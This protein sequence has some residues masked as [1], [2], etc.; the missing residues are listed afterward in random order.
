MLW[1]KI[2]ILKHQYQKNIL[3]TQI[4]SH[5]E[6]VLD[7]GVRRKLTAPFYPWKLAR[8]VW[9]GISIL[10]FHSNDIYQVLLSLHFYSHNENHP[11][12]SAED[13]GIGSTPTTELPT[14][15]L[16]LQAFKDSAK[17]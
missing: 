7:G 4:E 6:K 14:L 11:Q 5:S 10:H 13:F 12:T 17:V 2:S 3:E 16:E 9:S 1:D 8:H 15:P